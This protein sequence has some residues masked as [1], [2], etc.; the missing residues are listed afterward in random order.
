MPSIINIFCNS[1]L[2]EER[3]VVE[4]VEVIVAS[5]ASCLKRRL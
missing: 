3:D 5:S 1:G 2:L 4:I